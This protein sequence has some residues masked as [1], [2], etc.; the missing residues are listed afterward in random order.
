MISSADGR[1]E[2]SH[3]QLNS[4]DGMSFSCQSFAGTFGH[5]SDMTKD[6]LNCWRSLCGGRG[7]DSEIVGKRSE[8]VKWFGEKIPEP[9]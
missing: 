8:G 2:V 1:T 4:L 3:M 9:L 6:H 7:A 5:E